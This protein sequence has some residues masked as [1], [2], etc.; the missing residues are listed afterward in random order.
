MSLFR[1]QFIV[2]ELHV[3][4]SVT[5]SIQAKPHSP[6]GR[7]KSYVIHASPAWP[8]QSTLASQK[9]KH[10]PC[11][12][13]TLPN[14]QIQR[15]L[16]AYLIRWRVHEGIQLQSLLSKW[17]LNLSTVIYTNTK[18]NTF[19]CP[20]PRATTFPLI[21]REILL[22]IISFHHLQWEGE[23]YCSVK[24]NK[25]L[26]LICIMYAE[27]QGQQLGCWV[28]GIR[29]RSPQ[30]RWGRSGAWSKSASAQVRLEHRERETHFIQFMWT[31]CTQRALM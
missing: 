22:Q 11:P 5:L 20:M 21:R 30:E 13:P 12:R 27:V 16:L 23:S 14:T 18:M 17:P 31:A 9:T 7:T 29:W 19:F 10:W 28:N 4:F 15:W 24:V 25:S 2:S 26:H 8:R 3:L 1:K 6:Q